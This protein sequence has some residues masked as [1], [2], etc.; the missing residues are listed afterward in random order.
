MALAMIGVGA[1]IRYGAIVS[2]RAVVD[3]D[4]Y[5]RGLLILRAG[6]VQKLSCREIVALG[7][8]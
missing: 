7:I 5:L 4:A 1:F 3:Y 2:V 8:A 6:W